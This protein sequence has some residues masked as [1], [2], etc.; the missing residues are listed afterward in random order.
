MSLT[1]FD[2]QVSVMIMMK[3]LFTNNLIETKFDVKELF[4][5]HNSSVTFNQKYKSFMHKLCKFFE[6]SASLDIEFLDSNW[7]EKISSITYNDFKEGVQDDISIQNANN[8][9]TDLDKD[10]H[11]YIGIHIYTGSDC[12]HSYY[13]VSEIIEKQFKQY[14]TCSNY[15]YDGYDDLSG[16]TEYYAFFKLNVEEIKHELS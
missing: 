8:A 15:D 5:L 11:V 2:N 13:L 16:G 3:K 10:N 12:N 7:S 1:G 4:T 6:M 9:I 14:I